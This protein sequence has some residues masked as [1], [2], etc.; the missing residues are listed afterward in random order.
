MSTESKNELP[1]GPFD[2]ARPGTVVECNLKPN[3]PGSSFSRVKVR[4]ERDLGLTDVT[5]ESVEA[6]FSFAIV[7]STVREVQIATIKHAIGMLQATLEKIEA[8][9][10]GI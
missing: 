5:N 9:E 8:G 1:W 4:I 2:H 6:S 3:S 7:D 10:A